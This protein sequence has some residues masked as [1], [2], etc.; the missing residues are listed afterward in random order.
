MHETLRT[1]TINVISFK[2]GY[3]LL[4]SFINNSTCNEVLNT[5]ETKLIIRDGATL[6]NC[7]FL[8]NNSWYHEK[9]MKTEDLPLPVYTKDMKKILLW[10]YNLKALPKYKI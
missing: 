3:E 10:T 4:S 9:L 2:L 5:K 1:D 7:Q 6:E 8:E